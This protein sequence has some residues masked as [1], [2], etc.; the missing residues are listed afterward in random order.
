MAFA[1]ILTSGIFAFSYLKAWLSVR[2]WDQNLVLK[3]YN[4]IDYPYFHQ[5]EKLYLTVTLIFGLVFC[6][7]CLAS[8]F[9]TFKNKE[10]KVF[11]CFVLTM[12]T[13][14]AVMINGAIK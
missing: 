13:V 6:L 9:F 10:K 7:L 5:S 4:E 12:L 8:V 1:T 2:L 3:P 11:L 14:M